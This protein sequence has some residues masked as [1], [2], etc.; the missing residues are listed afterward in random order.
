MNIIRMYCQFLGG[1]AWVPTPPQTCGCGEIR[2]LTCSYPDPEEQ[3]QHWS[4]TMRIFPSLLVLA[5]EE[6]QQDNMHCQWWPETKGDWVVW[7]CVCVRLQGENVNA[8]Y[9]VH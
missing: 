9:S 5:T 1:V 8:N 3:Q 4:C 7:M 2:W 6:W